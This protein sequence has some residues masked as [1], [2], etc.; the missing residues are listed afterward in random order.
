MLPSAADLSNPLR[1]RQLLRQLDTNADGL[2]ESEQ[3]VSILSNCAKTAADWERFVRGLE[4]DGTGQV[5]IERFL[6]EIFAEDVVEEPLAAYLVSRGFA[7]NKADVAYLTEQRLT[8]VIDDFLGLVLKM[9]PGH[10]HR[11]GADYFSGNL[12]RQKRLVLMSS[13]VAQPQVFRAAVRPKGDMGA[14]IVTATWDFDADVR[15]LETKVA[16][17]VAEHGTFKTIALCCHGL[18]TCQ[19]GEELMK[20]RRSLHEKWEAAGRPVLADGRADISKIACGCWHLTRDCKVDLDSGDWDSSLLGAVST[21]A[22][23]AS[24]R[25]DIVGCSLAGTP[26]GRALIRSWEKLT[27]RNIAASTDCMCEVKNDDWI[28]ETDS[29]DVA[30]VY[31]DK[32]KL[33]IWNGNG[34]SGCVLCGEEVNLEG[35]R[36]CFVCYCESFLNQAGSFLA[37]ISPDAK[38]IKVS[39]SDVNQ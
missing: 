31:F 39:M 14:E 13:T 4:E 33:D 3:L 23:A 37:A 26:D 35:D 22:R 18:G 24:V 9:K 28:L 11:F 27:E 32:G 34:Q 1:A 38:P 30:A 10:L 29:I 15:A 7:L 8:A 6:E 17:L 5:G 25:L 36:L 2:I 20:N 16:N 19:T 12:A 21:I